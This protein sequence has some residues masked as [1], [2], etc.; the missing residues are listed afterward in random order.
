MKIRLH[1]NGWTVLLEDF[2]FAE[3]TQAQVDQ[4]AQ[5]LSTNTLVVVKNQSHLTVDDEIRICKM[6]GD[7][8]TQKFPDMLPDNLKHLPSM[9]VPGTDNAIARVTG[10]LDEHGQPG[11]FG[12]VS[13]LDW[14]CN[15]PAE[16]TRKPL[17]WLYSVKGSKGSRTSYTNNILSYNDLDDSEKEKVKDLKMVCGFRR[18]NYSEIHFGK[19]EEF[20]EF[21]TPSLVHT[22]E[23]NKTGL[24]FPFLQFRNFVGMTEEESLEIL[25]PLRDHILQEKYIY[26]H[27]W[28][29]GDVVIAE[30]WLGIHKRWKFDGMPNRV[31]HRLTFDYKNSNMLLKMQQNKIVDH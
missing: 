14:H 9:M 30:Q 28:D 12:H 11:L 26:H 15:R 5:F 6:F 16:P 4:I 25:Y 1:E 29:D 10:E 22:N 13:D 19:D 23:G 3:V 2:N 20:N 18:G 17:V 27:D 31:L 24:F 8:E 21:F 7:I